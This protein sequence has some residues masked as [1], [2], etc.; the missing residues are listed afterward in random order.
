M[1][2]WLLSFLVCGVAGYWIA[3]NCELDARAGIT[4]GLA[5]NGVLAAAL[6]GQVGEWA[7]M[8]YGRSFP[9]RP[10]LVG[11]TLLFCLTLFLLMDRRRWLPV[12]KMT[13]LIACVSLAYHT[14]AQSKFYGERARE[15]LASLE[16]KS[17]SIFGS[18]LAQFDPIQ[19]ETSELL[20]RMPKGFDTLARLQLDTPLY[21]SLGEV[22]P[23]SNSIKEGT[24]AVIRSEPRGSGD[25]KFVEVGIPNENGSF[26]IG[27]IPQSALGFRIIV[28]ASR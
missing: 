8:L 9:I 2:Y 26:D 1:L 24:W 7:G 13:G 4:M 18:S 5:M 23:S 17:G 27:L 28:P 11:C 21:S 19:M 22:R 15:I 3:R 6:F 10:V 20:D 16:K 25:V 14:L 12:L